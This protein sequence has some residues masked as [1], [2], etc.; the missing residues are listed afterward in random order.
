MHNALGRVCLAGCQPPACSSQHL[1]A[2]C[3]GGQQGLAAACSTL[4]LALP[5]G[6]GLAVAGYGSSG[7]PCPGCSSSALPAKIGVHNSQ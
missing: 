5:A 1:P 4:S 7:C 2:Q 6:R 3:L